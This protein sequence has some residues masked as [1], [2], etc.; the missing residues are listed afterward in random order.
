[1]TSTEMRYL[2][3]NAYRFLNQSSKKKK[4]CQQILQRKD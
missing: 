3:D 1:M 2:P 4:E